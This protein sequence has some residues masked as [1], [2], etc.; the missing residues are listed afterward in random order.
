MGSENSRYGIARPPKRLAL[1]GFVFRP[2]FRRVATVGGR[3]S[4]L[5]SLRATRSAAEGRALTPESPSAVYCE[6][7]K[8]GG[9]NAEGQG[10]A[11]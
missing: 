11:E 4:R 7:F 9:K 6:P 5:A 2:S 8:E 10:Q 3:V 1:C